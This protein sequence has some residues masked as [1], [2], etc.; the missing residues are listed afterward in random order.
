MWDSFFSIYVTPSHDV[1]LT[2][3]RAA[4]KSSK[5]LWLLAGL[6]VV[7]AAAA[8]LLPLLT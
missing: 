2:F 5:L 6:I 8:L 7:A 3:Q 1:Q 4:A